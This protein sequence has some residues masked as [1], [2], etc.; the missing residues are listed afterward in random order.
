M[1]S[2]IIESQPR[3]IPMTLLRIEVMLQNGNQL[4]CLLL[5]T[6]GVIKFGNK[7]ILALLLDSE[8]FLKCYV[9]LLVFVIGSG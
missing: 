5:V 1:W 9:L 2:P 7:M 4:F 3:I 6:T 8:H